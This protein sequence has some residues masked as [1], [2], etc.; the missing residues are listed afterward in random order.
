MVNLL[1]TIGGGSGYYLTSGFLPTFLKVVNHTPAQAAGFI[2]MLSSVAVIIVS[3]ATG[4][5]SNII[6]RKKTFLLVGVA[7]LILLPAIAL[8]LPGVT[9]TF[10]LA[11]Y[12]IV[13]SMLGSTGYAPILIFLNERFPTAIRATGTGLSWNIGFAIGGILPTF[14]SLASP[15][16]ADLPMTLALFLGGISV[17]FLIGAL[18]V[19]ETL[20]KLDE[21]A[22]DVA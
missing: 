5:L 11:I 2:M 22:N 9:D 10:M 17:I 15:T 14:V 7:R 19:P 21:P 13:F 4:H 1:L 12:V 16:P 20:G 3:V 6:G 8:T 18:I